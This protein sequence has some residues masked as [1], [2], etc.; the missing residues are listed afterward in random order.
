[1]K[2]ALTFA[3]FVVAPLATQQALVSG[4]PFE[5]SQ[6]AETKAIG[7]AQQTAIPQLQ[8]G[9]VIERTISGGE[10]HAYPIG[11]AADQAV[12]LVLNET[13]I[14]ADVALLRPDGQEIVLVSESYG[15]D[16]PKRLWYVADAPGDFRVEVRCPEG[17]SSK[18]SYRLRLEEQRAATPKDRS[19]VAAQ[20]A[21]I[22]GQALAAQDT[23]QSKRAA[24][25][26]LEESRDLWH[27]VAE[28]KA[29][30]YALSKIGMVHRKLSNLGPA[31]ESL[32][33]A[34]Q[35][36]VAA[37]DRV[38]EAETL[39]DLALTYGE[40]GDKRKS[41][42][43]LLRTPPVFHAI[44]NRQSEAIAL[45]N[46]GNVYD[47]LGEERLALEFLNQS[48]TI[49]HNIGDQMQES[50]AVN[51][52]GMVYRE[53]AETQNAL[54]YLN[55]ALSLSVALNDL[56]GQAITLNNLGLVYHDVGE[57]QKALHYYNQALPIFRRTGQRGP[58]G[59]VLLNI[60]ASYDALEE[61][62]KALDY[63][64][65]SL[66][67]LRAIGDKRTEART[68]VKI[69]ALYLKEG[70]GQQALN[71][72]LNALPLTK[73][74]GDRQREG[75]ALQL[76]GNIYR[77][78]GEHSKALEVYEQSLALSR[79]VEDHRTE[80]ETL[81]RIAQVNRDQADL[82]AAQRNAQVA[83]TVIESVRSKIGSEDLRASYFASIRPYYEFYIDLLMRRHQ[84]QPADEYDV[85]AFELSER[86]RAR[87]L[88]ELLNQSGADVREGVD[89]ALL[90]RERVLQQSM[91]AKADRLMRLLSGTH[92]DQEVAA[93][94]EELEELS[95]AHDE[96]ETRIRENGPRYAALTRLQPLRL[97]E[98]QRELE[99]SSLLLEYV[100]GEEHSYMWA[101][102]RE[103]ISSF[104]LPGRNRVE[105]AARRVHY[106]ITARNQRPRFE[107]SRQ[108][109][110]RVAAA[111][112]ESAKAAA[113]LSDIVI[114]PVAS[115][116]S[117]KNLLIVTDGALSYVPFAT[118]PVRRS[119][120]SRRFLLMDH[121]VVSLPSATT[122]SVLRSE[123]GKRQ[124]AE[125]TVAVIADPVFDANDE[126]LRGKSNPRNSGERNSSE[127]P[128]SA[129]T[130]DRLPE[131][132]RS[133]LDVGM[134]G[135]EIRITRLPF[136]RNEADAI[137]SLVPPNES[138]KALDFDA[139]RAT[140]MND[141]IREYRF[142]HFATH[143][144]LNN[145]H[146]E[147][148]GIV[149]SLV[150]SQGREQLG[151]LRASEVFNLRLNA[152]MVVLS[153]C[154]TG[155]GK[156]IKGEGFMGLTRGFMY[157][158]AK[159]LVVSR[160]AVSDEASANLMA[161]M[162]KH[163]L[164]ADKMTPAAALRAAQISI[165]KEKRWQAPYYWAAF[166]LEG[167]PR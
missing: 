76:I 121:E 114:R 112:R 5:S 47:M 139:S 109:A 71:E 15:S 30:G 50:I 11:I 1:M 133:A 65:Q 26:K 105:A 27:Q 101:I 157:A 85:R 140:A 62:V 126:R 150:D 93:L 44:G 68:L 138:K 81:L 90:Q 67:I 56:E 116:L 135:D 159:R 125:K 74:A 54:E 34:L 24:I 18:G 163:I 38:G 130:A 91:T 77:S 146:P 46:I 122:L 48:F 61:T 40:M 115:L 110:Q 64:R 45:G 134:E 148:T 29:E 21:F 49:S 17:P 136:T 161:R 154:Q 118:L 120:G 153:G 143:S 9:K 25:P 3:L 132:V 52:I 141:D 108:R 42:E 72:L 80:A 160:W 149:L 7:V 144:F 96:V 164:G 83:L 84:L 86:S 12:Q 94:R 32:Q 82:A 39:N 16:Q 87:S 166:V 124:P 98:I 128:R 63:C 66:T 158:G 92:R 131:V 79:S 35:L 78:R 152:E 97:N 167:E 2:T 8:P 51:N 43:Y 37:S 70:Q 60:G 69:G 4:R 41:L 28:T 104:Q 20:A 33:Q 88:I 95:I 31:L 102:T 142:V 147:L 129:M 162:Y 14:K 123:L 151:F 103:S 23:A 155:L 106:L 73:K 13:D 53:R 22:R 119:D 75:F 100:L 36:Y 127:R 19:R 145:V 89:A 117:R 111:D 107:T 6:Q 58:E 113:E 57:E 99:P 59:S 165:L 156:E 137:V 55:R 10:R